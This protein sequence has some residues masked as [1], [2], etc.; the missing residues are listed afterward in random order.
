MS[1][2][3]HIILALFVRTSR[4][5][6]VTRHGLSSFLF[7]IPLLVS[8]LLPARCSFSFE[9]YRGREEGRERKAVWWKILA[10]D[11]SLRPGKGSKEKGTFV[12]KQESNCQ[13]KGFTRR[14]LNDAPRSKDQASISEDISQ[15][16]ILP[17]SNEI[18]FLPE[19]FDVIITRGPNCACL[20]N[21]TEKME[22]R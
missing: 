3:E 18:P 11:K 1:P 15:S 20:G 7:L 8:S 12:E 6:C 9:K 13:I 16:F 14:I 19:Y 10:T 21:F 17:L 5:F 2:L 22:E 4:R